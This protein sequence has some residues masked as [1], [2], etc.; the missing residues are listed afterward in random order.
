MTFNRDALPPVADVLAR[1]NLA[2]S[3]LNGSG[4]AQVRCPIHSEDNPSLSIHMQ[5]GNWRCFACGEAG[6]DVLELYRRTRD[7]SFI[8]AARE[9]G[10]WEGR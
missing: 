10:A 1:L 5:R 9:L 2:A 7:I 8:Q 4:Y 6:G 3:R